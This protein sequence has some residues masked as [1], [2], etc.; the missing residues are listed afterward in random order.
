MPETVFT[1]EKFKIYRD[2]C[3]DCGNEIIEAQPVRAPR[4]PRTRGCQCMALQWA[5]EEERSAACPS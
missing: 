4:I 1:S 5:L 2:D 3:R